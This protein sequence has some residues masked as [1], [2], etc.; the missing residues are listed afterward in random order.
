MKLYPVP[1]KAAHA[2]DR[3]D[4]VLRCLDNRSPSSTTGT[5]AGS[6]ATANPTSSAS[7]SPSS[8]PSTSPTA[9]P[10]PASALQLNC[11]SI[12]GTTTALTVEATSYAFKVAC[13]QDI[14]AN[15]LD[16][17]VAYYFGDCMRACVGYNI[18]S[19]SQGTG[20]TGLP[21]RGRR[22]QRQPDL[23]AAEQRRQL[24]AQER[25]GT[26][27]R[28]QQLSRQLVRRSPSAALGFGLSARS[29]VRAR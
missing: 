29:S 24:L 14:S 9:I 2:I 15:N 3:W 8:G 12:D 20:G 11:P 16:T 1:P 22:V 28:Q 7:G 27:G 5:S 10:T 13:T 4:D 6:S 18:D 21:L 26:A 19:N 23:R 17:L 25:L